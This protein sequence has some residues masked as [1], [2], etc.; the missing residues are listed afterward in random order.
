MFLSRKSHGQRRLAGCA[1]HGVTEAL[2]TMEHTGR[3]VI[4]IELHWMYSAARI[5]S[6]D[7]M[8]GGQIVVLPTAVAAVQ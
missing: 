3:N 6:S 5:F 7:I 4:T 8:L 1:I 2:G